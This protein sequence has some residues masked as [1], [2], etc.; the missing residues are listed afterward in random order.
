MQGP[1]VRIGALS[2][3][4][5]LKES[6]EVVFAGQQETQPQAGV[7]PA[8]HQ[9]LSALE[10]GDRVLLDDGK[11]ELMITAIKPQIRARVLQGG[12]LHSRKV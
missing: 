10:T 1:E 8:E 6:E 2:A 9:V 11:L 4:L 12:V 5:Q 3:P 7:I